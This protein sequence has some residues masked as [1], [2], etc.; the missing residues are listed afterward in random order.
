MRARDAGRARFLSANANRA[1]SAARSGFVRA[2]PPD[3]EA[4]MDS[5][6]DFDRP[7][8]LHHM[9][10]NRPERR[11]A[12]VCAALADE[13]S[14]PLPLVRAGFLIGAFI[15]A[16]NSLV[17]LLYLALWFVTPP[18][19]G[20]RSALERAID[21]I[22]DLLGLDARESRR[23]RDFTDDGIPSDPSA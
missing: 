8:G 6:D 17:I 7:G 12:G 2:R 15:P 20:E 19:L 13:L 9:H 18:A 14:L 16:I 1:G 10:R 23:N 5:H 3:A 21:A 22:R 11:L 4:E